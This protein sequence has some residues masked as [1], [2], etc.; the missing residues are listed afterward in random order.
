MFNSAVQYNRYSRIKIKFNK[1]LMLIK[2]YMKQESLEMFLKCCL[3]TKI[4]DVNWQ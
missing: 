2:S 4:T 1:I 3:T